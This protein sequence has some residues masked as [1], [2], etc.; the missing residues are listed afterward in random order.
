MVPSS[1]RSYHRNDNR[2]CLYGNVLRGSE[3]RNGLNKTRL[4]GSDWIELRF[5]P[6][7]L[8][9]LI[10]RCF[11]TI[12]CHLAQFCTGHLVG[13]SKVAAGFAIAGTVGGIIDNWISGHP[14]LANQGNFDGDGNI[15][16]EDFLIWQNSFPYPAELSSVPEPHSLMLLALAATGVLVYR[17]R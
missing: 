15:D 17:R 10:D 11:P 6:V 1:K 16:G 2:G 3:R 12:E 13:A 14:L 7:T 9:Q 5:D 4:E 8:L